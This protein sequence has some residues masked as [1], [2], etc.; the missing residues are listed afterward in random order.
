MTAAVLHG[1][2]DLRVEAHPVPPALPGWLVL[3]VEETGICGTDLAVYRGAYP[4]PLPLVLGHEFSG[5]VLALGSD[6]KGLEVGQRVAAQGGWPCGV[7]EECLAGRSVMCR[8]RAL[9]GRTIDGSFAD[10]VAVPAQAV[11]PLP[12]ALS[13]RAAQAMTTLATA[14]HAADRAGNLTGRRVAVIGPGHAGL[15]LMQVCR[16]YS[17]ARVTVLGTR[18]GRLALAKRLGADDTVNVRHHDFEV[19]LRDSGLFDVTFEASGTVQGLAQAV[20]MTGMG[21]TVV[22]YGILEQDL[23]GVPAGDLYER[24]ISIV[25][26]RGAGNRY[27]DAL[28]LLADGTVRADLL[29]THII[30]LADTVQGISLMLNQPDEAVR[31]VLKPDTG[32]SDVS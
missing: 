26:A 24:E 14:L 3:A 18:P 8:Q 32:V 19:W 7:C 2:G 16:V 17:A 23:A 30:P 27:A 13:P 20:R 4:T 28:R 31:V 22:A 10:L 6:V 5:R 29:V 9:L 11:Y 25:G 21:G 12:D 15:M 1:P